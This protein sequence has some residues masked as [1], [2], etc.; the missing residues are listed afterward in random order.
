MEEIEISVTELY[1][2]RAMLL[3]FQI[4][5]D[6]VVTTIYTGFANE[7]GITEGTRRIA[8]KAAKTISNDLEL[9]D[10]QRLEIKSYTEEGKNELE[11]E[12][13]RA[14][15]DKDLLEDEIKLQIE[16]IDFKKVEDLSLSMN[17]NLLFEKLFKNY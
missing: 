3:G 17:Y 16:K 6:E 13:I 15:K 9:I 11:L 14:A 8:N 5:K 2:L 1:E 4:K 12:V 10:K 7:K